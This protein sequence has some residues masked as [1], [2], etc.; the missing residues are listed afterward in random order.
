MDASEVSVKFFLKPLLIPIFIVALIF[1]A[2]FLYFSNY[3]KGDQ[4]TK[5]SEMSEEEQAKKLIEDLSKLIELPSGEAAVIATV[6]DQT[7]LTDREF[8]AQAENG[9]KVLIFS[10]S[11]KAIL[12]RPSTG[13]IIEVASGNVGNISQEGDQY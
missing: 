7:K 2:G 4:P 3:Q 6:S 8:F 12:Y 9:D 11:K 1:T 10:K 5:A 13:K